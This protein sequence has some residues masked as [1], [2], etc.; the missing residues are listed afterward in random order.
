MRSG[1]ASGTFQ[2]QQTERQKTQ[3]SA[4]YHLSLTIYT[5]C[6]ESKW[7]PGPPSTRRQCIIIPF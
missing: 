7:R 1:L 6:I 3:K 2:E 5:M 4:R